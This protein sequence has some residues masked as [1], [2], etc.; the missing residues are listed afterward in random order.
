MLVHYQATK[1]QQRTLQLS[2]YDLIDIATGKSTQAELDEPVVS[3][4]VQ[5]LSENEQEEDTPEDGGS[6]LT[7]SSRCTVVYWPQLR[8]QQGRDCF[9]CFTS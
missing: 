3:D 2:P 1:L 5:Q 7:V 9:F 8:L 6:K 4:A